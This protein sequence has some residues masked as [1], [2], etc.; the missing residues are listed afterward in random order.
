MPV[1]HLLLGLFAWNS[2][3]GVPLK[4]TVG[5][6]PTRSAN[7]AVLCD[8]FAKTALFRTYLLLSGNSFG[9]SAK[10]RL[11]TSVSAELSFAV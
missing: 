3:S 6:N 7:G 11:V 1:T 5:S 8:L 10:S 9:S 2:K 4:G